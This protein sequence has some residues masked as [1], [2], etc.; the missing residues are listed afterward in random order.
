MTLPTSEKVL[1]VLKI[2]GIV[3]LGIIGLIVL[4]VPG[5]LLL[6]YMN[7]NGESITIHPK[8]KII[9]VENNNDVDTKTLE[10]AIR[11]GQEALK[12]IAEID[13][14]EKV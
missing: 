6:K 4:L 13:K 1:S 8:F 2:I 14:S 5:I 10:E 7:K 9:K 3:I 12:R 11:I